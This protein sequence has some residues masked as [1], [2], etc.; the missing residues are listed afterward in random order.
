MVSLIVATIDIHLY[1]KMY[2]NIYTVALMD[3]HTIRKQCFTI[4]DLLQHCHM[5]RHAIH[6][7]SLEGNLSW[8]ESKLVICAKTL[9]VVC[10]YMCIA[11]Q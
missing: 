3:V 5:N 9:T 1:T 8:L 4:F 11:Y 6:G 10:L 2:V 7:K